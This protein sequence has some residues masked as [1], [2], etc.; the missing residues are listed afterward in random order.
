SDQARR[1]REIEIA[2]RDRAL[3]PFFGGDC[4][5]AAPVSTLVD[6]VVVD[7]GRVVQQLDRRRQLGGA[8]RVIARADRSGE[9][10]ELWPEALSARLDEPA[11]RRCA[12]VGVDHPLS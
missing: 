8:Q 1:L 5:T 4:W 11:P 3:R 6:V 2:D 12:G 10:D 9:L 7:Q